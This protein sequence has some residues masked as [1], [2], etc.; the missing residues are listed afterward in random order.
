MTEFF[1]KNKWR[2]SLAYNSGD[3]R[4]PKQDWGEGNL[5][6]WQSGRVTEKRLATHCRGIERCWLCQQRALSRTDLVL[7]ELHRYS[8]RVEHPELIS[9]YH[10]A[11][12]CTPLK[13]VPLVSHDTGDLGSMAWTFEEHAQAT[14]KHQ[15]ECAI[16]SF[17]MLDS[18][19]STREISNTTWCIVLHQCS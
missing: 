12:L 10:T 6:T 13:T 15:T 7:W 1:I 19:G 9:I 4:L 2:G 8:L 3:W 11:P 16:I 18:K 17:H 14:A 5:Q